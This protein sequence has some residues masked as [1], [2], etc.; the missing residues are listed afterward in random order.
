MANTNEK[1]D[2]EFEN[3]LKTLGDFIREKR[4][5]RG[6]KSAETFANSID[7]DEDQ[8]RKYERGEI[9][10]TLKTL[11]KIFKGLREG[12]ENITEQLANLS[13]P[14]LEKSDKPLSAEQ[15]THVKNQV[16]KLNGNEILNT[17][18][19]EDIQRLGKILI[20]GFTTVPKNIF[21]QKVGLFSRSKNFN[22]VFSTALKNNWIAMLYP[23]SPRRHDQKYYTTEAGKKVL[24][25]GKAE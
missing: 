3:F 19:D 15:V 20:I 24:R 25:L 8:L 22:I 4:K 23:E 6:H 13:E 16:K 11:H 10:M 21:V 17:L 18:R 2:K 5:S 12:N 14:L 7:M 1:Q 9:P